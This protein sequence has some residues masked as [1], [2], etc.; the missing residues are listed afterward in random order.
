MTSSKKYPLYPPI[1]LSDRQKYTEN[2]MKFFIEKTS[3][4]L[5]EL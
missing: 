3:D 4:K 5:G 1:P 2:T